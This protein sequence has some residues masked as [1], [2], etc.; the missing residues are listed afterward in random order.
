ML[1][2][3]YPRVLRGTLTVALM[4]GLMLASAVAIACSSDTPTANAA[5]FVATDFAFAQDGAMV[6]G[7]NEITL[8]NDGQQPHHLQLIRLGEG[9]TFDDGLA[10]LAAVEEG[11]P[12]PE[13]LS[14][15][16]GPSMVDPGQS[17]TIVD[18]FEA[19]VHMMICFIPD[20]TDGV[21]HFVKGMIGSFEVSGERNSASLP[22]TDATI[23]GSD[24]AYQ[25][26]SGLRAGS[27]T[28]E[29]T[30]AGAELH[31]VVVVRLN[32]GASIQDYLAF[33][34]GEGPA[35][36]PPGV[37]I[38]GVQAIP[39]GVSQR[40]VLDLAAGTYGVLCFIPN[41]E[42]IPHFALGMFGQFEVQ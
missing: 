34:A 11:G 36:P 3:S 4:G 25:L 13:W 20:F 19:G 8:R 28:V 21:P 17:T 2:A 5:T 35:G 1:P 6:P 39:P 12:P 26:P 16:G 30:N 31:E 24:Y 40:A 27:R 32:Q 22:S 29:L 7:T 38:G 10:A 9:K 23:T 41:G 33:L 37:A 14:F 42:G 18:T 15:V